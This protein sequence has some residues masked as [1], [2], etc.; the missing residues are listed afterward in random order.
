MSA[1]AATILLA[2]QSKSGH[3]LDNTQIVRVQVLGEGVTTWIRLNECERM[4]IRYQD[5]VWF[6]Y[7]MHRIDNID[8]NAVKGV[9]DTYVILPQDDS[10]LSNR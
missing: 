5:T 7:A 8:S 6:S 4:A 9:I 10:L 2:C 1:A 3:L